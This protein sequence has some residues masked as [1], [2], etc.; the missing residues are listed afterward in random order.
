MPP[1]VIFDDELSCEVTKLWNKALSPGTTACYNSG[2]QCFL[3]FTL[4]QGISF[5]G[6]TLPPISEDF[7]INFVTHCTTRL[8]LKYDT[9]KLYLAGIRFHYIRNN[10]GDPLA[11][12]LRLSYI[13]RAIK[14]S[15]VV[16]TTQRFP[17]TCDV[18]I[19]MCAALSGNQGLFSPFTDLLL[20]CVFK[21]AFYGFMR[22]GEFTCKSSR[23]S[24]FIRVE[25]IYL[26][27]D[28]S[29]FQLRLRS[30]KTDPY[31]R[32]VVLK[33]FDNSVLTPVLTMSKY[34]TARYSQGATNSSPLFVDDPSASAET[35]L[36]R[37]TFLSYLRETLT[38]IGVDCRAFNGHSFRIGAATSAAAAGI[39]DH[40]IQTLGRW[41]SNCYIRYI[42]TDPSTILHAQNNMSVCK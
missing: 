15:L 28:K 14:K 19:K 30:S 9:I 18:L 16:P 8:K 21:T 5:A 25:D 38:R 40:V 12:T 3:S 27:P 31:G 39:E 35:P 36:R 24:N 23:E 32:G 34:L 1:Y 26:L 42:H 17:I 10:L 13:L 7:L 4:L 20:Q 33:I 11:G 6:S 29:S 22:C 2:L 41:S 37:H